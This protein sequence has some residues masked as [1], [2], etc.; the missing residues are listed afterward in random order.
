[1]I[2]LAIY[3]EYVEKLRTN[4]NQSNIEYHISCDKIPVKQIMKVNT[5]NASEI[6]I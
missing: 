6:I 4:N 5:V 2:I 3:V 1:M